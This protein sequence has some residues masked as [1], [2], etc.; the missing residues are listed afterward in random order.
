M[1][2]TTPTA[3]PLGSGRSPISAGQVVSA[4]IRLSQ[5]TFDGDDLYW[6]EQRPSE[7][8]RN[9]VVR[10]TPDGKIRDVNLPPFN[11]RTRAHEYGGGAYTVS[12]GIAYFSNY[13]DQRLF[14][15]GA[16]GSEPPQ[17]LSPTRDMRYADGVVDR[18]RQRMVLV[19]EDHSGGEA[20]NTLVSLDLEGDEARGGIPLAS[21]GDF[22]ASPRLSPDG[23]HLAWLTWN[24]PNMPWDGC[25]LWVGELA[26]GG[27]VRLARHVA[28]GH[29]ESIFQPEWSPDG[30]LH[31]VSDRTGWWNLYRLRD[32]RVEPLCPMDA[33]FGLPQWVFG[34]ST[35]AFTS[36][37]EVICAYGDRGMSHLARLDTA[38]GQL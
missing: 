29:D 20:V 3:S 14:R 2:M 17:P 30:V 7:Q 21:G 28:G 8:G 9:V 35:Y 10:R 36:G 32:G 37:G 1:T 27:E 4:S 38:S 25:E 5:L 33:E 15:A 31:F 34:L 16:E 18:A 24:H 12:D 23:T 22:Y 26:P 6:V 11:A 13:D 19:R